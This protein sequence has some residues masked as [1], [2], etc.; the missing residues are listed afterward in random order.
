MAAH[1]HRPIPG[2]P[3]Q[4]QG[5]Q[6]D[7]VLWAVGFRPFFLLLPPWLALALLGWLASLGGVT[8]FTPA[9]ALGWH[10]H[11]M[12]MGFGGGVLGGFLLTAARNWTRRPTAHGG[13]LRVLV[14]LWVIGRLAAWAELGIPG[15][16]ADVCLLLGVAVAIGRPIVALRQWRNLGFPALLVA[17]AVVDVALHL[18]GTWAVAGRIG[19]LL[20]LAW[21]MVGFGGRIVPLFTRNALGTPLRTRG[22]L[23]TLAV[24][25][26]APALVLSVLQPGWP[27]VAAAAGVSLV[28]AGVLNLARLWGWRSWAVLDTP[29]LWTLHGGF[30][31]V[32]LALVWRGGA[33]LTGA[34]LSPS[35]HLLTVGGLC[36]LA[37]CMMSRVSMGHTGRR[38]TPPLLLDI[39]LV[40]VPIAAA[41]RVAGSLVRGEASL[42]LLRGGGL[43]LVLAVA[44]FAL[45]TAP[46]LLARRVDGKPG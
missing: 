41:M 24:W 6:K 13:G 12:L 30:A 16:V 36:A 34:T 19:G 46:W 20:V 17:L 31:A 7:E 38:L 5:P 23:D 33:L 28:V 25:S 44:L 4:A 1:T 21:F 8:G 39:A 35:T 10:A 43:L 18:G 15:A 32:A 14:A 27:T 26:L 29:L 11:E 3:P 42:A 9:D 37:L 40:L 45:V 2:E 22:L